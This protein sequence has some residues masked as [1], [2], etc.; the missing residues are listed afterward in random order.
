MV[1]PGAPDFPENLFP[2]DDDDAS[3]EEF[4]VQFHF[5]DVEFDL[6]DP[7]R[8]RQWVE[9]VIARE[10]CILH[11]VSFIYCSD[12]YLYQLNVEYLDHDTL[13]DVITFPYVQPP[14]VEGDIFISADRVR[15][16]ALEFGISFEQELRRVMIHGVLHLCGYTDNNPEEKDAMTRKE[17][18]ALA[19]LD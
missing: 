13:T 15:E 16:N 4:A 19:L 11:A 8:L 1:A 5:E 14:H 7:A 18:E 10:S 12:D 3:Q 17:N 9:E 2:N 6:P